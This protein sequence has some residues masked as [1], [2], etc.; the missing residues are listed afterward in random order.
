MA[1]EEHPD[2]RTQVVDDAHVRVVNNIDI[3]VAVD[4]EGGLIVP[5][6]REAN[7]KDLRTICRD[8]ADITARARN[9]QLTADDMGN[10]VMTISNVGTFGVRYFTPILNAPESVILGVGAMTDTPVVVDGGIFV[11]PLM[12]LSLTYDHRVIN[13]APAARFLTKIKKNLEDFRWV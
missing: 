7:L 9:N 8:L 12:G 5:V 10:A 4:I 3:G 2:I 6:I 13:G 11:H 1:L